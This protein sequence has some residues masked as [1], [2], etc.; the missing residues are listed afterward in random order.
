MRRLILAIDQGTTNNKALLVD[1][2]GQI[3]ARGSAPV[4]QRYPQPGWAESDAEELWHGVTVAIDQCLAGVDPAEIAAVAISNQREAGMAWSRKTGKPIGPVISW[5]CRRTT[6]MCERLKA[7]GRAELIESRTGLPIDPLFTSTKARWLL[8]QYDPDRSRARA[9]E[10][11]VGT[12]DSWLLWNFTGGEVFAT[13]ASNASRT[14][15]FDI[16]K[17]AWDPELLEV[18]GVPREV[19]PDVRPSNARFG[20][21]RQI[22]LLPAGIPVAGMIGDS[23]GAMF[24]HG[25]YRPGATKATY[26]TGSSLMCITP[27]RPHSRHGLASTIAWCLSDPADERS[28]QHVTYALEGN[29][30]VTGMAVRW[31]GEILGL[32]DTEAEMTKLALSV[33]D[34]NEVYFVP[35]FA[36]LG[37][38]RWAPE[39]RGTIVG[40]TRGANRGHLSRACLESIAFQI[41]DT[42]HALADDLGGVRP[43]ALMADG[44]ASQGDLL[45]QI[46]SDLLG[47][48]VHRSL[49]PELSPLGAAYLAGIC[50]GIWKDTAALAALPHAADLF[51]PKIG[52]A[53]RDARYRG[54][55]AALERASVHVAVHVPES[56][57]GAAGGSAAGAGGQGTAPAT[58]SAA[59]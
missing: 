34:T 15:L 47:A 43:P 31:L 52:E 54:W 16:E 37:A 55:L 18:F 6:D 11:C 46:Q 2:S 51:E 7:E 42:F 27:E 50:V 25:D 22:G 1:E 21:T 8:D 45:M 13:D 32:A 36:G 4:E 40:L 20:V 53:E 28:L 58:T 39:A 17:R 26:G 30:S 14:Q 41:K 33:P 35:A 23:H 57:G 3:L 5:Q 29:I 44:G 59:G 38:P 9:G 12:V 19:L 56:A 48:S 24:G 10:L 49:A